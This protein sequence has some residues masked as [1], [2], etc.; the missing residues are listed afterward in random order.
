LSELQELLSQAEAL[1]KE[2]EKQ[3]RAR[4][5]RRK[6]R[7]R[8][9]RENERFSKFDPDLLDLFFSNKSTLLLPRRTGEYYYVVPKFHDISVG[10]LLFSTDTYNVFAVSKYDRY[11]GE[12]PASL[13]ELLEF[14]KILPLKVFDG[15][16]LTGEEHQAEALDKY[17][18]YLSKREGK[19][20]IRVRPEMQFDL[21]AALIEDGILPFIPTPVEP[22]DRIKSVWKK[23]VHE[24]DRRR[25]MKFFQDAFKRF[26]DTGAIG[27]FWGMGVGKTALGLEALATVK[28]GDLPNLVVSGRSATLRKQ[29]RESLELIEP[30]APVEIVT[31]QGYDKVKDMEFGL[32]IFD[33]AH[34]LPAK[35]F[36]RFSTLRAKYRIGLSATPYREDGRSKLIFALTGFPVGLNWQVLY[37]LDL[38]KKPQVTVWICDDYKQKKQK[39]AD[40]LKYKEKTLIYCFDLELGHDLSKTFDIPFVYGDTKVSDRLDI[41]RQSLVTVVSSIGKEGL[42]FRKIKRTITYNFFKGSRQEE[43]QFLGRLLHGQEDDAHHDILMTEE[44][45][46][47]F[48][49]RVLGIEDKGIRVQYTRVD[50]SAY[51]RS[52]QSYTP[53][54]RP[55][56]RK[57]SRPRQRHRPEPK[58]KPEFKLLKGLDDRD[59]FDK[60]YEKMILIVLRSEYAKDGIEVSTIKAILKFHNIKFTYRK[61]RD[62]VTSLY[63][64]RKISG[65]LRDTKRFYYVGDKQE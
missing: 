12:L 32:V 33:E 60:D 56:T 54:T 7:V 13:R 2:I 17:G 59:D 35:T 8:A 28:V 51:V 37:D 42:S 27:V 40:L 50:G 1:D 14:G 4:K 48:G 26:L 53:K 49:K 57:H 34:N 45:D 3:L 9:V 24:I 21:I 10:Y 58:P 44:E 30:A 11:L 39:I 6:K 36:S 23:Q 5:R 31:Y 63:K 15:V 65:I 18:K 25:N 52:R 20:K 55:S 62:R 64:S 19:D 38:I 29:W 46:A 47:T 22:T 16:M 43:T 41:I 61:L